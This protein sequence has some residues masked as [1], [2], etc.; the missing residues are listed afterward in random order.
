LADSF[1]ESS[2]PTGG[3]THNTTAPATT[4]P[5]NGPRPASSTPMTILRLEWYKKL[6][7]AA[8]LPSPGRLRQVP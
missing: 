8:T 3:L 1:F 2:R 5:A 7:T 6:L 4:G